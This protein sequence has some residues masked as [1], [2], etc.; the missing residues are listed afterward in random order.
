MLDY[1]TVNSQG[2]LS[3]MNI[4]VKLLTMKILIVSLYFVYFRGGIGTAYSVNMFITTT[5]ETLP[6]DIIANIDD[7]LAYV[8]NTLEVSEWP[9]A[10]KH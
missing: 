6:E 7:M 5:V 2:I 9:Q 8:N 3:Q 10:S 1:G 4:F